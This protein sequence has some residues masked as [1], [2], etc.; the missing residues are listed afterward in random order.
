VNDLLATEDNALV[1]LNGGD[2]LTLAFDA[3]KLPP[4]P[5]GTA[6]DFFLYGVGWDKDADFHVELG[7]QVGPLPWHGMDDQNYGRQDRPAFP[8]DGLMK[9]Y[10]TRWIT[11]PT[12]KRASR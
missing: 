5:A 7:W 2:E 11:Q 12:L 4:K 9:Q 3:T 6:R 8:S 10:S 1:L